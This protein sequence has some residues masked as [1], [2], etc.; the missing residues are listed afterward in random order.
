M[1]IAEISFSSITAVGILCRLHK[2]FRL[3][4]QHPNGNCRRGIELWLHS[5]LRSYK[6]H[7][8]HENLNMFA[9]NCMKQHTLEPCHKLFLQ[10][11][12]L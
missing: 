10:K 8:H 9:S 6:Y 12:D 2:I 4:F 5:C 7:V 11:A 3:S 1:N